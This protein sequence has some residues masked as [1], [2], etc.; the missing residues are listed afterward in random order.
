MRL[1]PFQLFTL[2]PLQYELEQHTRN[3]AQSLSLYLRE[4]TL[5]A[6]PIESIIKS[7]ADRLTLKPP[8]LEKTG[9]TQSSY[10]SKSGPRPQTS[11]LNW[12]SSTPT[13]N[14]L[15][16][17][18]T[19]H[20]FTIPFTGLSTLFECEPTGHFDTG[21]HLKDIPF[22]KVSTGHI[23]LEYSYK[24]SS[25]SEVEGMLYRD[26]DIIEKYLSLM[27]R[28]VN[29]HNELTM[30]NAAKFLS[31]RKENLIS[32]REIVA[33][34]GFPIT[35]RSD[36]SDAFEK[37]A[38]PKEIVLES[39][40]KQIAEPFLRESDYNFILSRMFET[41]VVLERSPRA[42]SALNEEHLRFLFLVSLNGHFESV[43]GETFNFEGKTD[44]LIRHQGKN[45]FIAECKFWD[46]PST[47][48]KA[49]DQVLGYTSWRDTNVAILLFVRNVGFSEVVSKVPQ[50]AREHQCCDMEVTTTK[51][52]EFRFRFH[53]RGDPSRKIL[54][55]V[56][57]FHTPNTV[58]D[59]KVEVLR[60]PNKK[61]RKNH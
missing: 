16:L 17:P 49:I 39:P 22:A 30:S 31:S 29:K 20:R 44:I 13:G 21:I 57:C 52:T 59:E 34:L 41:A 10:E 23:Q 14:Q 45:I 37:P 11:Q 19:I 58:T 28:D 4:E 26:I 25:P 32:S 7:L 40:R 35:P 9:I 8:Q 48:T 1:D 51:E 55:S 43:T 36:S 42:F 33:S 54:L 3:A 12:H 2:R 60:L 56:L 15:E 50:V 38:K 27:F 47:L 6:T 53:R 5:I 61:A 24:K 46:G 18:V